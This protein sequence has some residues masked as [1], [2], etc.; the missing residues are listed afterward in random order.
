M[1][2][3]NGQGISKTMQKIATAV[4]CTVTPMDNQSTIDNGWEWGQGYE[5]FFD[6]TVD[7]KKGDKLVVN[8]LNIIIQGIK[9]YVGMPK[10]SHKQAICQRDDA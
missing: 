4:A 7:I 9:D 1:T 3:V 5:A 2:T 6:P 8:S 10:L